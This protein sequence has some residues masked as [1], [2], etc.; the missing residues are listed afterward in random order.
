MN[1]MQQD[2]A[3]RLADLL[4]AENLAL[5]AHDLPAAAAMLAAKEAAAA[6][7]A[8]WHKQTPRP[9][10]PDRAAL[11]RVQRLAEENRQHLA[12]ALSVQGKVLALL[13]SASRVAHAAQRPAYGPRRGTRPEAAHGPSMG[14]SRRA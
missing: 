7:L 10:A 14:M 5:A 3:T 13:A 1:D 9:P 2:P 6:A 12:Q 11:A 4:E 8:L